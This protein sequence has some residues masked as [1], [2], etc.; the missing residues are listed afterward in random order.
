MMFINSICLKRTLKSQLKVVVIVILHLK[1]YRGVFAFEHF[2]FADL[3]PKTCISSWKIIQLF[4]G[5]RRN[6]Y[7][8]NRLEYDY[9]KV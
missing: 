2:H 8:R 7:I 5:I 6:S 4:G 9:G 1:C 3:L